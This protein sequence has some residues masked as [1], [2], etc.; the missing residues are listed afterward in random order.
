M[1]NAEIDVKEMGLPDEYFID[2]GEGYK[3]YPDLPKKPPL[4][5]TVMQR[6][7]QLLG[8]LLPKFMAQKAYDMYFYSPA[9][10]YS[11][12]EKA[13]YDTA[14]KSFFEY[15]GDQM[16][17]YK[18]GNG[19]KK[20]LVMHGWRGHACQFYHY[21]PRLVEQGYTVYGI[22]GPNHGSSKGK[23]RFSNLWVTGM[24]LIEF[25]KIENHKYDLVFSHSGGSIA[26]LFALEKHLKADYFMLMSSYADLQQVMQL[27]MSEK[28]KFPEK[29]IQE[30]YR[31]CE[32]RFG[33]DA[34]EKCNVA[35]YFTKHNLKGMLIH[36]EGDK[37]VP[38]SEAKRMREV[39]PD[40]T[41]LKT[42]GLGHRRILK[43]ERLANY[44]FEILQ[45][46]L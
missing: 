12:E 28:M 24:A 22:D 32:T 18:W 27:Q 10:T 36:D 26:L 14:E 7:F 34:W 30:I 42:N 31:I 44:I 16:A 35:N 38:Y 4:S 5:Q 46:K 40:A 23:G 25:L 45:E 20:A 15:D 43:N 37:E 17:A 29:L 1:S 33:S 13:V 9:I 19:P 41:F 39:W 8:Y 11:E 2:C 6:Q 21:I 3:R